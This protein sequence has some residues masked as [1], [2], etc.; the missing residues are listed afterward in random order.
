MA[1]EDLTTFTELDPASK[2]VV[3][4]TRVTCTDLTGVDASSAVTKDYGANYF[5]AL[6]VGFIGA[7]TGHD[8]GSGQY[9]SVIFSTNT[10]TN[11][12]I[13]ADGT[14]VIVTANDDGGGAGTLVRLS[15]MRGSFAAYDN[16]DGLA[17]GSVFYFVLARTAGGD[18]VTLYIYSDS[19]YTTLVDTL[20]TTGHST[21]KW[22]Y[23]KALSHAPDTV[24]KKITLYYEKFDLAWALP[25][26][27]GPAGPGTY[28]LG[29]RG[30][31]TNTPFKWR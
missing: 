8:V 31:G 28:P 30:P 16:V 1:Y 3:T 24:N 25:G 26:A 17:I 18:T 20:V 21:I 11:G 12:Y 10:S 27:S 7:V 6:S 2:I 22:R 5:D 14:D 9:N 13:G 29:G 23:L 4:A 19:A 15:L